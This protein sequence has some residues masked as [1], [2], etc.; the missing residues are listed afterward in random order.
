MNG[1]RADRDA[2]GEQKE[3]EGGGFEVFYKKLCEGKIQFCA[4]DRL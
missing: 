1:I 2:S 3:K 4:G